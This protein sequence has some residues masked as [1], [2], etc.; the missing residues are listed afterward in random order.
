VVTISIVKHLEEAS[1]EVI[2]LLF[3]LMGDNVGKAL[4]WLYGYNT[5]LQAVPVEL[6]LNGRVMAVHS[7]L[8]SV[9]QA[10]C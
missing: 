6:L 3:D 10:P 9:A 1:D 5:T 8:C 4:N 7:Y 2:D